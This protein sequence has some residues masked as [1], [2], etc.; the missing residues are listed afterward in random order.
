MDQA[1]QFQKIVETERSP[2]IGHDND[3]VGWEN[4][5]PACWDGH[6]LLLVVMEIDSVLVPIVSVGDQGELPSA[7]RMEGV[8]NSEGSMLIVTI[9]CN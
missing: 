3:G 8:S 7:P 2:P 9:G 5:G 1:R 6:Q 4:T